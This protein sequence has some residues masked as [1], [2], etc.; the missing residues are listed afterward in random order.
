MRS[1][2]LLLLAY[3]GVVIE[4]EGG[5]VFEDCTVTAN[6]GNGVSVKTQSAPSFTRYKAGEFK[7]ETGLYVPGAACRTAVVLG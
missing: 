4:L 2:I 3:A 5:G 7:F 6:K 1:L